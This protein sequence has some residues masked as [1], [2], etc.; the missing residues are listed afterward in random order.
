ML[1]IFLWDF[2]NFNLPFFLTALIPNWDTVG[3]KP[4]YSYLI[5][6]IAKGFKYTLKVSSIPYNYWHGKLDADSCF[7]LLNFFDGLDFI[8]S[9]IICTLFTIMFIG[10]CVLLNGDN[11]TF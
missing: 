3:G 9:F 7:Y 10:S 5:P 2:N 1:S 6:D 4:K 8:S 11:M